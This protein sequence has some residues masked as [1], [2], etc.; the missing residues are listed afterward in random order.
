MSHVRRHN[1]TFEHQT[2][3]RKINE[4]QVCGIWIEDMDYNCISGELQYVKVCLGNFPKLF[5]AFVP[6]LRWLDVGAEDGELRP[7]NPKLDDVLIHATGTGT[8]AWRLPLDVWSNR[9]EILHD[10]ILALLNR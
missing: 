9:R 10:Q 3:T 5:E 7:S 2:L 1:K 8:Q 6:E 4:R